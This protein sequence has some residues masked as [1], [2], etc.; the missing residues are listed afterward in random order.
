MKGRLKLMNYD[1]IILEMFERIKALE[2]EMKILKNSRE[3]FEEHYNGIDVP[4]TRG[5]TEMV[6]KYIQ[7]LK[8]DA[9]KRGLDSIVLVASDIHK[10]LNLK[11]RMPIICNAM[12]Q[13]MGDY[14][15]IAHETPSG[16]SS[17]FSVKYYL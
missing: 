13:C 12:K 8:A 5:Q 11:N 10:S 16:Y 2:E 15:E 3:N 9:K 7:S 17:T 14:D 6:R 4:S 1:R